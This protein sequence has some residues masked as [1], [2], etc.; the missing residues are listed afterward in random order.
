[1]QQ[2]AETTELN[3]RQGSES[4]LVA[5]ARPECIRYVVT[6]INRNGQRTLS[7]ACQYWN[8][9]GTAEEAQ[10]WIEAAKHNNSASVLSSAYDGNPDSVQVRAV[11][12]WDMR[13]GSVGDPKTIWFD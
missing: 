2:V 1:M 9:F 4:S 6:H 7:S 11:E 12:C 5:A 8:T 3:T 10:A 13:D